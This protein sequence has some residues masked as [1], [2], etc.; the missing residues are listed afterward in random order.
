L[1]DPSRDLGQRDLSIADVQLAV[2]TARY[3][4]ERSAELIRS[5]ALI[6]VLLGVWAFGPLVAVLIYVGHHGGVLTGANGTE[7]FDQFQYLAW[8]RDE[9]SHW[10]GSNLWQVS[11]TPHD[12]V[13]PMYVISGLLWR[14]GASIQLAYLIWKPVA[15]LVLF[16]GFAAYCRHL[17]GASRWQQTAALFLALFYETPVLALSHWTG[18]LSPVHQDSLVSASL[19]SYAAFNLWGLEHTAIAI[20]LVPVFLIAAEKLLADRGGGGRAARGW[21]AVAALAGLFVSWLHPWQGVMLLG[22]VGGLAVLKPP[23]RRYLWL[24]VPVVATLLPL[25]YGF[26][27]ARSDPSWSYFE[28]QL[29]LIGTGRWWALI[30]A[31]GPLVS[32]AAL[33]VRR[34][35]ADREWILILWLVA[36]AGVYFL[37]PQFPPH[38]LSGV[39][40]PLS[41]LAVLGWQR[42][43]LARRIAAP[44]AIAAILAFTV[45]A[46]YD[47][48]QGQSG[49]L[50]NALGDGSTLQLLRLTGS[51]SAALAYIEHQ[52]RPGAVLAPWYLSMSVPAFTGRPAYTGHPNWQP[53]AQIYAS[54]RFFNPWLSDR[55]GAWHRAILRQS[56]ARFLIADCGTPS[57]LATDIA[58]VA[59]PVRRFG[60]LTVFETTSP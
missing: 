43:R 56:K 15:L 32:L 4:L 47:F 16:V 13:H 11:P 22:I 36:C 8:I 35:R 51:Q 33:G 50:S 19:D 49:M 3:V 38:A 59:R 12:Y 40:L 14:L 39:T 24:A 34:P 1:I 45:P 10:L 30:A 54:A 41:V 26:V 21:V 29:R 42:L 48:A 25:I 17:L 18:L 46:A 37:I 31:F 6:F 53:H 44:A 7:A 58:P 5:Q 2:P 52:P 60:C 23:R 9:G 28:S 20:G 55:G 27:L 57:T